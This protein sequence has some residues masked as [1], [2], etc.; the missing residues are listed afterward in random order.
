VHLAQAPQ[1]VGEERQAE[2]AHGGVD[3]RQFESPTLRHT[4]RVAAFFGFMVEEVETLRP[5]ITG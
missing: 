4:P 2:P 5:I 3:L 1:R